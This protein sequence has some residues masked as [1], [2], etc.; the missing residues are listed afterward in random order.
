[1]ISVRSKMNSE[2]MFFQKDHD[3]LQAAFRWAEC[4]GEFAA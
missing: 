3:A 4:E 2:A 1:M